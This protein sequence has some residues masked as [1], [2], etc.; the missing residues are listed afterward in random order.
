MDKIVV[1]VKDKLIAQK[2]KRM[3]RS[4]VNITELIY[5]C[6]LEYKI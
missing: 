6:I 5:L 3:R 1:F 4:G 2:L